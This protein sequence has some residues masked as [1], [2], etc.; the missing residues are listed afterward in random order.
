MQLWQVLP[1]PGRQLEQGVPLQT[2][3]DLRHLAV[4]L[5]RQRTGGAIFSYTISYHEAMN[6][7]YPLRACTVAIMKGYA[8]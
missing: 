7:F 6:Y 5:H 8:A 2:Q 1:S 4:P 3:A